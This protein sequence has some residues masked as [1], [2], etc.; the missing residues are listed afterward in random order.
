MELRQQTGARIA[1]QFG[2]E[3]TWA[4]EGT[5]NIWRRLPV[6]GGE[7]MDQN[8]RTY[9]TETIHSDREEGADQLGT[10]DAGGGIPFELNVDQAV[11]FWHA[12]GG[13]VDT[14][15][16]NPWT[17][18]IES[19]PDVTGE[20]AGTPVG[21]TI[22]KQFLYLDGAKK[23]LAWRGCR[24]DALSIDCQIDRY[25][26]SMVELVGEGMV[27]TAGSPWRTTSLNGSS[28][29]ADSLRDPFKPVQ[30]TLTLDG[31][32][33]DLLQAITWE[34]RN[35]FYRD[36]SYELGSTRR[37]S[38][39]PGRRR[40]GGTLDIGFTEPDWYEDAISGTADTELELIFSDG[41]YSIEILHPVMR[42]YPNGSIPKQADDGP[43]SH[44]LTWKAHRSEDPTCTITM[45]LPTAAL[46]T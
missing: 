14:S 8:I 15:G 46:D 33:I 27:E 36:R 18:V 43:M 3:Q 20:D 28:L 4:E 13:E 45:V 37:K 22:E 2:N 7:S 26:N 39:P 11:F 5:V 24:V 17:H 32:P 31:Y 10:Q 1:W 25:I 9:Q 19:H 12:L 44:Q 21:L 35:N 6:I 29:P 41:T 40:Y 23:Y 38:L 34:V 42:L 30:A 16:S